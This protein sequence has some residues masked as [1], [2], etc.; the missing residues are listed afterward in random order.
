VQHHQFLACTFQC[1]D[2]GLVMR[3][4]IEVEVNFNLFLNIVLGNNFVLRCIEKVEF[5]KLVIVT[6]IFAASIYNKLA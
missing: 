2:N 5:S 3:D 4:V 6:G 1:S